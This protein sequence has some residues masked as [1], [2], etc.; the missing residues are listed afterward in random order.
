MKTHGLTHV[1]QNPD[2]FWYLIMFLTIGMGVYVRLKGLGK[3]SF[4]NDEYYLA[5]SVRSILENG[6]PSFECGGYYVRG[7]LYQY[8]MV[9]F[10][11][12]GYQE[13]LIF[14]MFSVLSNLIAIPALYQLGK[15]I[16]SVPVACLVVAA[17]SISTLEIEM[18]RYARMYAPFQAVFIWY[19]FFLYKAVIQGDLKA[20][21]WMYWLSFTSIFLFEGS[22]FLALLNFLPFIKNFAKKDLWHALISIFIITIVYLYLSFD[23]RHYTLGKES[24]WPANIPLPQIEGGSLHSPL[25]MLTT[26]TQSP[27]W[28][29]FYILPISFSIWAIYK[30]TRAKEL[31]LIERMCFSLF[32]LLAIANLYGL[33]A[34]SFIIFL[35][36]GV[37]P[38]EHLKSRIVATVTIAILFNLLFWITYGLTSDIWI[39][40][41][42]IGEIDSFIKAVFSQ[43]SSLPDSLTR[44]MSLLLTSFYYP[45]NLIKII[46][47]WFKVYPILTFTSGLLIT[48]GIVRVIAEKHSKEIG[49]RFFVSVLIILI[50]ILGMLNVSPWNTRYHFFLFPVLL[51]LMAGAIQVIVRRLCEN[52]VTANR[53]IAGLFLVLF[54]F[55][56]D[57]NFKHIWNI[58]SAAVNFRKVY[59]SQ[60]FKVEHYI[61]RRDYKG[62]AEVISREAK[63]TDIVISAHQTID[64][65][66]N[67]LD[68]IFIEWS[69][70]H[71]GDYTACRGKKDRWTDADLIYDQQ[72][73]F[74]MVDN[75][76]STT[77]I[78]INKKSR[79]S[80]EKKVFER[81]KEHLYFE[82]QDDILVILKVPKGYDFAHYF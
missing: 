11:A 28:R 66:T 20:R 32:I 73:L 51:L 67:K 15:K 19:L 52:K 60:Y 72:L 9:P 57:F 5:Q 13:E 43:M 6:V 30:L 39:Q 75:A 63:D 47:A 54:V 74:D 2:W 70:G 16:S 48:I 82:A 77:W 29:S 59:S 7:I 36:L 10:V 12:L 8:L 58:D 42:N 4:T 18:S 34:F 24:F 41:L 45:N 50:L 81:Y 78:I 37:V 21:L 69:N 26:I 40:V 71:F 64:Y 1:R 35:L 3:W 62:I 17:Y 27:L 49:F 65:Y 56:E 55:S 33:L 23:F 61:M 25:L 79:R 38:V 80:E 22:I 46:Y 68:Y 53:I 14:R 44:I 76:K 31:D